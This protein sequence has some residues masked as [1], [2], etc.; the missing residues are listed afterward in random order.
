MLRVAEIGVDMPGVVE[1]DGARPAA[2]VP[3]IERS[4]YQRGGCRC[5]ATG[6]DGPIIDAGRII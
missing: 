1:V 6:V 5:A 4:R 3:V 2:R